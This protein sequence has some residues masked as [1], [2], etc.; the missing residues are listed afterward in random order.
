MFHDIVNSSL[1]KNTDPTK[2]SFCFLTEKWKLKTKTKKVYDILN[3][4]LV[5]SKDQSITSSSSSSSS[6]NPLLATF[7]RNTNSLSSYLKIESQSNGPF[8]CQVNKVVFLMC[9]MLPIAL[10]DNSRKWPFTPQG[11]KTWILYQCLRNCPKKHQ[12]FFSFF[13]F[14][15][16]YISCECVYGSLTS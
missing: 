13:F 9:A 10:V 4:S 14:S 2:N 8:S 7:N 16:F 6:S 1:Q 11:R 12:L 15:F 3:L 5:I